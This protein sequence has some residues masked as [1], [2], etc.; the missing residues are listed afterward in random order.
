MGDEGSDG[1][2]SSVTPGSTDAVAQLREGEVQI[3]TAEVF[4]SFLSALAVFAVTRLVEVKM[5]PMWSPYVA[6][7]GIGLLTFAVVAFLVTMFLYDSLT[8]PARFWAPDRPGTPPRPRWWALHR[9]VGTGQRPSRPP[10]GAETVL[11]H[12]M[13]RV[14]GAVFVPA[15][16]RPGRARPGGGRAGAAGGVGSVSW[17]AGR[18]SSARSWSAGSGSVDGLRWGHRTGDGVGRR[19]ARA[20]GLAAG[21]PRATVPQGAGGGGGGGGRQPDQGHERGRGGVDALVVVG[22]HQV[23]EQT[24]TDGEAEPGQRRIDRAVGATVDLGQ[25]PSTAPGSILENGSSPW[26]AR[27]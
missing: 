2:V 19:V 9:W 3:D 1:L 17:F 22:G 10:V 20:P 14:W 6:G 16:S 13:M 12:G 11:F 18:W 27:A 4:G 15:W 24:A 5:P 8:M 26:A 25:P 21:T 23:E 7:A